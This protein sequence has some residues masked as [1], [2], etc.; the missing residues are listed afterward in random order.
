MAPVTPDGAEVEQDEFLLSRGTLED[1]VSPRPPINCLFG[2]FISPA[3]RWKQASS[4][5]GEDGALT[6]KPSPHSA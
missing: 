2:L 4:E 5:D 1:V 3:S 6:E